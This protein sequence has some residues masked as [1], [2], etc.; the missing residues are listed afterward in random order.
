L[1]EL[2]TMLVLMVFL[3]GLTD[4]R[5]IGRLCTVLDKP[6]NVMLGAPPTPI[7]LDSD[8]DVARIRVGP[9][10][11]QSACGDIADQFG[12]CADDL[13]RWSNGLKAP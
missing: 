6:V 11:Y 8:L 9:I 10:R 2:L 7:D 5:L 13:R 3:P 12:V 1:R 4:K